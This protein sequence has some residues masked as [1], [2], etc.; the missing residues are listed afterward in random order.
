MLAHLN[1]A[2]AQAAAFG[3]AEGGAPPLSSGPL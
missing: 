3:I 2:Q 1:E